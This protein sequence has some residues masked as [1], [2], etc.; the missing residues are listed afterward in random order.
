MNFRDVLQGAASVVADAVES[1]DSGGGAPW[2]R[3]ASS[4]AQER[5]G[6][7]VE[8]LTQWGSILSGNAMRKWGPRAVMPNE[9]AH[10]DCEL[11]ALARC[12]ICGQE[13]CLAHSFVNHEAD[14]ICFVCA[15]QA[16]A[17]SEPARQRRSVKQSAAELDAYRVLG[18][19][20]GVSEEQIEA[21]YRSLARKHHPD[22]ARDARSRKEAELNLREIN[23]AR[24]VL[25]RRAAA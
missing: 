16:G 18:L 2:G 19:R 6:R 7:L 15:F 21:A 25:L 17:R 13:H 8:Q 20:P 4:F 9:C 10:E 14:G 5:G 12:M 24:D 11:D 3:I 1:P 22:R 23:L